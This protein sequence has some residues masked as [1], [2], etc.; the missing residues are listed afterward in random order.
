MYYRLLQADQFYS[1]GDLLLPPPSDQFC[2]D[3]QSQDSHEPDQIQLLQS[4]STTLR[5]MQRQLATIQQQNVH[6]DETLCRLQKEIKACKRPTDQVD[7]LE[8][9]KSKKSRKTPRG[10]SVRT[11][12]LVKFHKKVIH[13]HVTLIGLCTQSS[14]FL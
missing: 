1:T 3:H 11:L 7:A 6:R 13:L 5:D 10:L 8:T 12:V 2:R 9:P 14:C 4:I